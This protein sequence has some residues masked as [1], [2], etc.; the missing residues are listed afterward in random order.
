MLQGHP[1]L[2]P[3]KTSINAGSLG[4]LLRKSPHASWISSWQFPCIL[5][6][7]WCINNQVLWFPRTHTFIE[8]QNVHIQA[9]GTKNKALL[10]PSAHWR[11]L[12][13]FHQHWVLPETF[14]FCFFFPMPVG[15]WREVLMIS[16]S[17][18]M[19]FLDCTKLNDTSVT[20][21]VSACE[22]ASVLPLLKLCQSGGRFLNPVFQ[23]L[24]H[25]LT[26]VLQFQ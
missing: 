18:T 8:F 11:P 12:W 23:N 10:L 7:S 15:C 26:L 17:A 21:G 14:R 4:K 2:W 25:E 3:T 20:V 24:I 6:S 13:L 16:L 5:C 22:C 1:I 9:V 19:A